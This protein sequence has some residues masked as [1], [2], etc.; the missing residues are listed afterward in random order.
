MPNLLVTTP[1]YLLRYDLSAR[2]VFVIEAGRS[3]YYGISWFPG[4][5]N[6]LLSHSGTDNGALKDHLDYANSE[7]GWI[8]R[9]DENSWP[10]V[11]QPH[12]LLC[13]DDG[14]VAVTNTGRN[15]LTVVNPTGWSI[16]HHRFGGALWDRLGAAERT[17]NHF[18]SV[19]SSNGF[20]FVLAHNFDKGSYTLKLEQPGLRLV[21]VL[22]HQVS[23]AHNIWVREDGLM[24]ACDTM[25]HSI[26]SLLDGR[27]LWSS[28]D[29]NG[30]T[31]G[32]AA[33]NNH[34]YVGSSSYSARSTRSEGESGIWVLDAGRFTTVDYHALGH[35]GGVH[36]IRV[37]DEPDLCHLQ[38]P[39]ALSCYL[40]GSQAGLFFSQRKLV[41]VTAAAAI[42]EGWEVVV[43]HLTGDM[44][45]VHFRGEDFGLALFRSIRSTSFH[46]SGLL[47]IS[48]PGAQHV[49]L[50]GRY[51]GPG[52]TNMVAAILSCDLAGRAAVGLW[53]AKGSEWLCLDAYSVS[54][55]SVFTEFSGEGSEFTIR[56]DGVQ[57]IVFRDGDV[58]ADGALGVR[59]LKGTVRGARYERT[60][61]VIDASV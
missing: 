25:R 33:T 45:A 13:L 23:G 46:I 24:I 4:S 6:I 48:E 44:T 31:R 54:K 50:V 53:R 27:T 37:L 52:D 60:E 14:M 36:D 22:Q 42:H 19:T 20:L 29:A 5:A 59:G 30:L 47:D 11:S 49:A 39:I 2:Q 56:C 35:F 15:C 26:S 38:G 18:N 57:A 32:L 28:H 40:A 58:P 43:G 7:V 51:Q 21:E 9:G 34:I 8:S 61:R 17:G 41:A 1:H 55:T 10:F 3:E 12:Q 16:R